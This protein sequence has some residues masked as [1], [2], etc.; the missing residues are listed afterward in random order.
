LWFVVVVD[1]SEQ[2]TASKGTR[3]HQMSLIRGLRY[4]SR[5]VS[6][7]KRQYMP[8]WR[9]VEVGGGVYLMMMM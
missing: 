6:E 8:W 9:L 5:V 4:K 1:F 7:G 2:K 3:Q